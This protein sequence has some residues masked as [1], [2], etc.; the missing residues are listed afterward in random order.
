MVK[1]AVFLI[2]SAAILIYGYLAFERLNYWERSIRIFK[3]D[4]D[5]PFNGRIG[6]GGSE[7]RSVE[8]RDTR[9]DFRNIPD[10]VRQR[11]E[12]RE[13]RGIERPEM[14]DLPDSLRRRLE[15]GRGRQGV[16]GREIPDSLR[17]EFR[18]FDGERSRFEGGIRGSSDHGRGDIRGQKIN[19]RNV[20]WFT[21]VFAAFT[22]IVIYIDKL[23]QLRRKTNRLEI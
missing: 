23:F 4:T 22:V 8:R 9:P 6:R 12:S 17:R 1:K 7:A 18:N 13:G 15:K 14:R 10:S 5:Q 19:L 11:Y 20:W 2:I 21:A 16:Q 3:V